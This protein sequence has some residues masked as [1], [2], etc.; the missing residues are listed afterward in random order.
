M[1]N[2]ISSEIFIWFG[3]SSQKLISQTIS[4]SMRFTT[5]TDAYV[6]ANFT[7]S[8]GLPAVSTLYSSQLLIQSFVNS[9]ILSDWA[10]VNS[11]T[12]N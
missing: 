4:L 11:V 6:I 5:L 7:C 9:V 2:S 12:F 3:L 10:V 1:F 8:F